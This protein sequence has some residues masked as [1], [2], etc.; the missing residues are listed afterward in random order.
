VARLD[1]TTED[2]EWIYI[3]NPFTGKVTQVPGY[4][5]T[6]K[7]Y[8]REFREQNPQICGENGLWRK[9]G[10]AF[11]MSLGSDFVMT[12]PSGRKMRYEKVKLTMRIKKD[13]ETGLPKKE[14]V[15]MADTD[16]RYKGY[17][18]GKLTENLVQATARD[19]FAA[20]MIAMEANGWKNL[21]SAH[22][23]AILEVDQD[24][25][26]KDVEHEMSKCPDWLP[27]CPIAAEAKEVAH[28]LK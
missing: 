13:P 20:Q 12:L 28:Y 6:S 7:K 4:G 27:G 17:Y 25:T 11:K 18:G 21:F 3:T 1:I 24:V 14:T 16:G 19:V 2:P 26:A 22:D 10:D 5:A 15:F 9:L 23:E 8:V